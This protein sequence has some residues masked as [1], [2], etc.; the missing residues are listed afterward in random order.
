MQCLSSLTKLLLCGILTEMI[1]TLDVISISPHFYLS[2]TQLQ[3][4]KMY[5]K[6]F[7]GFEMI[8]V[9]EFDATNTLKLLNSSII[10][11]ANI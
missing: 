8:L 6:D 1:E 11:D 5:R 2:S 4:Y 7:F 3:D 10:I 9:H